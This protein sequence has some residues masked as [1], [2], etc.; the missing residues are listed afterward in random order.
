MK[1]VSDDE[2]NDDAGMNSF[3]RLDMGR[4]RSGRAKKEV[5]YFAESDNDDNDMF[6]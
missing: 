6:D 4:D 2:D 1:K 3:S 5:K